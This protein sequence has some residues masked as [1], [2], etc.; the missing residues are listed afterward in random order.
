MAGSERELENEVR[1]IISDLDSEGRWIS[2]YAGELLI[3]QTKFPAGA[4]YLSSEA[5]SA[6]LETLARYV[7]GTGEN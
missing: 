5:F 3:G 4:P 2:V 6:N 7:T 1:K